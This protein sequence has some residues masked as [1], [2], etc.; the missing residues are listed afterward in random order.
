M[1]LSSQRGTALAPDP[2]YAPATA[3]AAARTAA[4]RWIPAVDFLTLFGSAPMEEQPV[5]GWPVRRFGNEP[6]AASA[7]LVAPA[8]WDTVR[9]VLYWTNLGTATGGAVGWQYFLDGV[10]DGDDLGNTFRGGTS[11]VVGPTGRVV[12]TELLS[13]FAA[14]PGTPQGFKLVRIGNDSSD[15]HPENAG[16]IGVLFQPLT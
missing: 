5:D 15:T 1:R 14:R 8:D 7:T 16:L 12:A 2:R 6:V 3:V 11:P 10:T 4:Y 13:G 9:V